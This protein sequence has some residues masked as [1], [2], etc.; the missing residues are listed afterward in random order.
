MYHAKKFSTVG[1]VPHK[2]QSAEQL[3]NVGVLGGA[4]VN[5]STASGGNGKQRLRWTS[6]LHDRFVD[7]ITQLGGPDRA[8]PKGVLRVMGVPG[9]TI[10]HVKSHLQ[11]YR[12]A[13][14]LPE[15]SAEGSKDEKKDSSDSLSSMDSAPGIQINEALR[16]QMEV[17]KR[18]QEQLEVQR[19]LQLRIEAQGKYL[20]KI[21]EEQQK[22]GGALNDPETSAADEKD[23]SLQ[24]P[25]DALVEPV[26]PLKKQKMDDRVLDTTTPRGLLPADEKPDYI[27]SQWDRELYGRDVVGFGF[28]VVTGFKEGGD[29]G[30]EQTPP[31][32]VGSAYGSRGIS[33]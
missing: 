25:Q 29:G 21:I 28:D 1:L 22:L 4:T 12:L 24:T 23:K 19:Q 11:K 9:L 15:S 7:A 8:T 20:Q 32:A 2:P 30:R 26:S 5:N 13:K 10:Y 14:Y 17:Q 16:M 3:A 18:L 31:A 6:E 33:P 27:I